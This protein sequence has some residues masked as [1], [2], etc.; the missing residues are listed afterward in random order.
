[1]ASNR[2]KIPFSQRLRELRIPWLY[3]GIL[4]AVIL[5]VFVFALQQNSARL[6]QMLQTEA[7][8]QE[9]VSLRE[10]QVLEIQRD[11]NSVGTMGYIEVH[12]RSDHGYLKPGEIRFKIANE[13]I[14][15]GYTEEEMQFILDELAFNQ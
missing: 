7:E 12:A 2:G 15:N 1:L 8:M 5:A 3:V 14:L 10:Q 6:Q 11:L 4:T 13:D 9:A